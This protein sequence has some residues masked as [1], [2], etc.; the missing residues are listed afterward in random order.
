VDILAGKFRICFYGTIGQNLHRYFRL[1]SGNGTSTG[2]DLW[3]KN[4]KSAASRRAHRISKTFAPNES[5]LAAVF[6]DRSA[7]RAPGLAGQSDGGALMSNE[8]Q[9]SGDGG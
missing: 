9:L 3:P 1:L 5:G 6:A 4:S 2:H 8:A 7:M